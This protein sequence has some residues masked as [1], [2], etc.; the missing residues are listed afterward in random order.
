M[1]R[2]W[3]AY[4]SVGS[5]DALSW[6]TFAESVTNVGLAGTYEHLPLFNHPPLMGRMAA[7]ALHVAGRLH[8]PFAFVFKVPSIVA[9]TGL[10]YLLIRRLNLAW[11]WLLMLAVNPLDVMISS[12]HGNTDLICTLLAAAATMAVQAES[13]VLAGLA[14]GAAINVKLIPVILIGPLLVC[15]RSHRARLYML[16]ALAV[17]ALPFVP[18]LLSAPEAFIRNAVRYNSIRFPWGLCLVSERL[19]PAFP[20]AA[21]TLWGFLAHD[22]K[23]VLLAATVLYALLCRT[24]RTLTPYK[25]G[26]FTLMSFLVLAPG[27]G[28]Q[29]LIYPAPFLLMTSPR[30]AL[31]YTLLAG[32]YALS[33]YRW[34]W[35][36]A[37]PPTSLF[38]RYP[39]PR[40]VSVGFATWLTL[41]A[42]W[43]RELKDAATGLKQR[44]AAGGRP[45]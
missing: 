24:A 33:L 25:V 10:T 14:V 38:S 22:A 30:R 27:F 2:L 3:V 37:F 1:L 16:L 4:H 32:T 19:E 15:L 23:Y 11:P 7:W 42:W 40:S 45:S 44:L 6:K 26:A 18:I 21:A 17:C 29:Y 43:L 31:I 13:P 20:A 28:V 9:S 36:G 35:T 41:G 5:D 8:L 34:Y 39:D 12:Y